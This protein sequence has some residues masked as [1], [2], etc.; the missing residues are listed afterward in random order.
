MIKDAIFISAGKNEDLATYCLKYHKN[1]FD[2]FVNI[3]EDFSAK[4]FIEKN[5]K[6]CFYYPTTKFIALSRIYKEYLSEYNTV[7]VFDDDGVFM[8]GSP[9]D[10][11]K[12][13]YNYNLDIISPA[14][15]PYGKISTY[16]DRVTRLHDGDHKYRIT[17]FIEMNFPVF[18]N[19][20]LKQYMDIYDG[21]LC[22]YGNDWWFLNV[23]DA[24]NKN[25]CAITDKVVIFN[26][27]YYQKKYSDKKNKTTDI[28]HFMSP[29]DRKK[30]W[31]ETMQKYDL[32]M[33]EI[34][35]KSIIY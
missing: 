23:L 6:K 1:N 18:K 10:L 22:G 24:N 35:N 29:N 11:V 2:I 12:Y 30:Q 9:E 15:H 13:I 4:P 25:N 21:K 27:R 7:S 32:K 34:S 14:Q 20:A 33:W 16:I 26:P 31:L 8:D 5:A 19:T 28:D 3:Y 17:N